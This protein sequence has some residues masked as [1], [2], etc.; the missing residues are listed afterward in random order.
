MRYVRFEPDTMTFRFVSD[1]IPLLVPHTPPSAVG[2]VMAE[3]RG[4]VPAGDVAVGDVPAGE[5]DVPAGDIGA[6]APGLLPQCARRRGAHTAVEK[7]LM[8]V[9]MRIL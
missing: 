1:R 8:V 7:T 2:T 9:T 6:L 3:L 5:I 4:E